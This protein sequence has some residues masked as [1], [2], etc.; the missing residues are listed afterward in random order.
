MSPHLSLSAAGDQIFLH[1]DYLAESASLIESFAQRAQANAALGS[2]VMLRGDFSQIY[3]ILR[4][5]TDVL[6]QLEAAEVAASKA[7][8]EAA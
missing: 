2:S 4:D 5:A 6:K 7:R 3:R 1:L 8:A